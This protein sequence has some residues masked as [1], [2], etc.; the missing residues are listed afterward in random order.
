MEGVIDYAGLFPPASLATGP[1]IKAYADARGGADSWM[2]GRF[3]CS[4]S[5]LGE[6]DGHG[7][8]L[9]RADPPFHFAAIG[10]GGATPGVFLEGLAADLRVIGEFEARHPDEVRFDVFEVKLP[11]PVLTDS[12]PALSL[13][14]TVGEVISRHAAR[15]PPGFLRGPAR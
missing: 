2:L 10:R 5:R 6:L 15:P 1:A 7:A 11:A 3:V 9:F 14:E 12:R 8:G 13:L 4:A